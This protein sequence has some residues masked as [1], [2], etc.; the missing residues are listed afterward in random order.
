LPAIDICALNCVLYARLLTSHFHTQMTVV[1]EAASGKP[2]HAQHV[3]GF[4][5]HF[6][7]PSQRQFSSLELRPR[8]SPH[9]YV[10][11]VDPQ[12][13]PYVQDLMLAF[14]RPVTWVRLPDRRDGHVK[15]FRATAPLDNQRGYHEQFIDAQFVQR[16]LVDE[17]TLST[18]LAAIRDRLRIED[19]LAPA[20]WCLARIVLL[21]EAPP[22]ARAFFCAQQL[23][24][25]VRIAVT[26]V[27]LVQVKAPGDAGEKEMRAALALIGQADWDMAVALARLYDKDVYTKLTRPVRGRQV[28]NWLGQR[29]P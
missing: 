12:P 29:K 15:I 3:A 27:A 6:C 1:V 13:Q 26:L 23:A 18:E 10:Q 17:T 16:E 19:V 21:T 5:A 20:P 22:G 25:I 24:A 14:D 4:L 11:C 9:L 28:A 8:A 2:A 7:L